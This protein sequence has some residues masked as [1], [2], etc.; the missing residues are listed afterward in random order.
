M[1]KSLIIGIIFLL[2]FI[3][4]IIYKNVDNNK[5]KT[6]IHDI[7]NS[8]TRKENIKVYLDATFIAG[9]IKYD[10]KNYYVIFGDGVQYLV[11]I[12]DKKANEINKYLLDNP[13]KS[14]QIRGVTK[15]IPKGIE[16]NGIKFIKNYL[17]ANH[18]HSEGEEHSHDITVDEFYHYFGYVYLDTK[19]NNLIRIMIYIT[20]II[21]ALFIVNSLNKEYHLL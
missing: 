21:S 11:M 19:T 5:Y 1:K 13:E 10:N 6:N 4:L 17:D 18:H 7:T 2:I 12:D 15:N 14:Y 16:E 9:S 20:G 3:E 8:G